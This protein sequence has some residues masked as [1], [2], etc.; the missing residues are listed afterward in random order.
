M[1]V[2]L[3][4][5][6][7]W[8]RIRDLC[9][10]STHRSVAVPYIGTGAARRLPLR[11]G[12]VLICRCD[13]EMVRVGSTN[14]SEVLLFL[15][16]GVK[17]HAVRNLHA[18]VFVLGETAIV[19]S[20]NVSENSESGL[21]EAAIETTSPRVVQDCRA[22]VGA[23][24]GDEIG[25]EFVKSLIPKY[26]PP[27]V[28]VRR[29]A[30]TRVSPA[31]SALCA[32]RISAVSFDDEDKAA[33][34]AARQDAVAAMKDTERFRLDSFKWTGKLPAYLRAGNRVVQVFGE[35][36]V[37]VQ[38]PARITSVRSYKSRRGGSAAI[39]FLEVPKRVRA[40]RLADVIARIPSASILK[41]LSGSRRLASRDLAY[42][43]GR[44]WSQAI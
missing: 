24:I 37:L 15:N 9:E 35:R 40:R 39:V 29:R 42:E 5:D 3:H 2:Q 17:V 33:E 16:R 11:A 28:K 25:P 14:P 38:V 22:F 12:D 6:A 1:K 36:P 31:Q 32:V 21:V 26:R 20:T 7:I 13:E 19:G 34:Q 43:L 27:R 10:R 23:L 8:P 44:L 30:K 18:K 41:R 4:R